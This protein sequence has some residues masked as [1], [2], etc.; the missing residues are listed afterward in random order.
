VCIQALAAGAAVSRGVSRRPIGGPAPKQRQPE[1]TPLAHTSDAAAAHTAAPAPKGERRR[2]VTAAVDAAA[3]ADADADADNSTKPSLGT[4]DLVAELEAAMGSGRR[5]DLYEGE[6]NGLF[7]GGGNS[8]GAEDGGSG[9]DAK[10]RKRGGPL[11]GR[12]RKKL[13]RQR[14]AA[15][16]AGAPS[17]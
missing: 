16:T 6:D 15:A 9:R 17:A 7:D 1:A 8:G 13:A 12:L 10:K 3:A 14:V 2:L 11:G 4:S 5:G